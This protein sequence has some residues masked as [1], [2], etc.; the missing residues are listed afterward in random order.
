M[1]Y[2]GVSADNDASVT[3]AAGAVDTKANVDVDGWVLN[4]L[5]GYNFSDTE[6]GRHD[7]IFGTRYLDLETKL[8]LNIAAASNKFSF[9]DDVWDG[10]VGVR[11]RVNLKG[12]WY[13]QY[14]LDVGT[15][16]SD[17]TWQAL[18]GAGYKYSW[19]DLTFAYRHLEWEFDSGSALQDINFS[20]PGI[21]AKWY[22]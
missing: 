4:F 22:F 9:S 6:K 11:G 18:A 2:L 3:T 21:Q 1:I 7:F 19:G 17:Y 16:Q 13:L 12:N 15:G 20:G 10:V 8:N 14:Y 5:A